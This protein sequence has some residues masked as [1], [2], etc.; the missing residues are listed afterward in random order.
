VVLGVTVG[1]LVGVDDDG[2]A[3]GDTVE[4]SRGQC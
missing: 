4:N 2:A 1:T 3:V